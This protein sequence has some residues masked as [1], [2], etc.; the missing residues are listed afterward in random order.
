MVAPYDSFDYPAYWIGRGYEDDAERIAL[1]CFFKKIGKIDSFL[2]V[3]GGFGRLIP[4]YQNY[5]RKIILTDPSES[6][7]SLAREKFQEKIEIRKAVLPVLPF[8]DSSFEAVSLIRVAHHLADLNPTFKEINRVLKPGGY[9]ILEFANK[10]HFL[11]RIKALLKGDFSFASSLKMVDKR[12][13]K[14]LKENKILF[15]NHHPKSVFE[16]LIGAGFVIVDFLSVSNLRHP[17]V[18]SLL[19]IRLM[20]IIES[21][22][23][24][25]FSKLYFGPSIFVLARKSHNT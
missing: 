21:I 13:E 22:E 5:A 12:T 14:T 8:P 23:Q 6:L 10:V 2:E 11:A 25:L 24:R 18:K 7:L 3:G 4:V 9:F 20:L 16:N 19:P 17:V 15:L 1:N